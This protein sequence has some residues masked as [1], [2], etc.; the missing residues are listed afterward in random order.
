MFNFHVSAR[1]VPF[2]VIFKTD[3]DEATGAAAAI[4][5]ELTGFPQGTI[6]FSLKYT[7]GSC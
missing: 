7:Q 6:G 5:N 3:G 4:T 1:Q 2:R